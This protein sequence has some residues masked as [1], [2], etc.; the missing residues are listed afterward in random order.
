MRLHHVQVACPPGGEDVAR[1]F[2]A[3]ALGLQEVD[4]PEALRARGG[5]WFRAVDESGAVTAEIHVGVEDP[6]APARKA[7]PAL[8][9]SNAADLDAVRRRLDDGGYDVDLS[10]RDTFPGHDRVHTFDGHGNR[11]ELLVARD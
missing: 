10:Q 6:F 11:V 4:K 7:H 1:R 2:Y 3:G 9:L 5:A 8:V